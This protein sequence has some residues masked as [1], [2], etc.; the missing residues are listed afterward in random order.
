[1]LQTA[2]QP[3]DADA[4]LVAG[5]AAE[6]AE[7]DSSDKLSEFRRAQYVHCHPLSSPPVL[8]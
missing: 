3:D 5:A 6:G 8:T 7:E 2:P 1:M 4:E